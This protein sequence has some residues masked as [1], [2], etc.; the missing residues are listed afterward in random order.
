ME[1]LTLVT[2]KG[3]KPGMD[4]ETKELLMNVRNKIMFLSDIISSPGFT[5][6]LTADG[7]DGFFCILRDI[8]KDLEN[9]TE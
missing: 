7:R 8:A 5:V 1:G 2:G 6:E 9:V 3:D 4:N